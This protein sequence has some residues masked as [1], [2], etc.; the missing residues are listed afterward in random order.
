MKIFGIR[1]SSI[2]IAAFGL[3]I[4]LF[5]C[6]PDENIN[7]PVQQTEVNLES[8]IDQFI[9]ENFTQKY[10]MAIRYRFVDR[11]IA[12]TQRVTPPRLESVR[13][14]LDFI[15]DFWIEPY[16]DIE[17]GIKFFK[18]HVPAEIVLLGGLIFNGDGTVTLGTADAG[19][20]ITFTNVNS[21]DPSDEDWRT[22]QLQTVYHEFAHI[23]HQRYKLPGSF[24]TISPI[25][26]TSSGSWF[27][28]NDEEALERG[29]TS[30]YGTSSPNEDFA[31][32]V[33]FFLFDPDFES[34]FMEDE[35]DC[36]TQEC[37]NRNEGRER[38]RQKLTAISQHYKK[39]V[40][41]DLSEVRE[42]IQTRLKAVQ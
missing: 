39:V 15:E 27:T 34:N 18:E 36:D 3:T 12:P 33:S 28:L 31:E 29:F 26:Y 9:D 40:D 42:A 5:S 2:R 32:L 41:I 11:F 13:P 21:V 23:I 38:I 1:M 14:M 10:G 6:Y 35:T 4:G 7:V 30:P 17:G 37:E 20:Q 19:A 16:M 25:G 8:E 22:L 24:E